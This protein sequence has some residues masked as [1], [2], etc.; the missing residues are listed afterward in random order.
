MVKLNEYLTPI[1]T[2][3]L[4]DGCLEP[5][6]CF[7][8]ERDSKDYFM[9][10]FLYPRTGIKDTA[11]FSMNEDR[12]IHRYA[13]VRISGDYYHGKDVIEEIQLD[14]TD[15]LAVKA[16]SHLDAFRKE[17][18][19]E[20]RR[21]ERESVFYKKITEQVEKAIMDKFGLQPPTQPEQPDPKPSNR[22]KVIDL[23]KRLPRQP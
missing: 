5:I 20:F 17:L 13:L 22:G 19:G 6:E 3:I 1:R 2:G 18:D 14:L 4:V 8:P 7:R 23:T 21:N 9:L 15:S 16:L 10:D 11:V 12:T